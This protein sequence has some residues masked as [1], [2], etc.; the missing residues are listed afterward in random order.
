MLF[1]KCSMEQVVLA[2]VNVNV[3]YGANLRFS[4]N[5]PRYTIAGIRATLRVYKAG[6]LG[7]RT[8]PSGRKI[9]AASW[10]ARRDFMREL[11]KL[12][13]G[14]VISTALA[15]Y[16]GVKDFKAKFRATGETQVGSR[17]KPVTIG[18]LTV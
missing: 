6:G 8:S 1:Q 7:A 11:Y 18:D 3:A 12:A 14:A 5:D 17:A 4:R 16:K 13:P 9:P 2:L 10:E 15:T